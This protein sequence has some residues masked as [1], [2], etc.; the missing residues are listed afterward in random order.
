MLIAQQRILITNRLK[1]KKMFGSKESKNDQANKKAAL[2]ASTTSSN[3]INSIVSGT[4]IDG[5]VKASNDFRIDGTLVGNLDC[6]GKVIIGPTGIVDGEINC[7]NALIEGK[8]DGI[9][10]VK[11]LLTVKDS[12]KITGDIVT[13]KLLVQSGAVFNVQCQMGGQTLSKINPLTNGQNSN[14]KKDLVLNA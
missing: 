5:K 2:T 12:A 3:S 11:E 4:Q 7:V 8:F 1:L 10:K 6:S 9:L 14:L 13:D